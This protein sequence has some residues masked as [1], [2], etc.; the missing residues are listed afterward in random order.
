MDDDNP[1]PQKRARP[2]SHSSPH[3]TPQRPLAPLPPA[4]LLLSLP[5][6]LLHPPTHRH[7]A[8]SLALSLAALRRC[9]ALRSLDPDVE[10]R[11][12]TALA[13]V[14]ML[15]VGGGF[16]QRVE[17]HTWAQGVELEV[18]SMLLLGGHVH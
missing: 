2:A 11:A 5:A 16:S 15:V 12:W 18:C 6:L 3:P 7:H 8:P 10:C 17:E 4:I 14:G 9:L 13:E 1:R